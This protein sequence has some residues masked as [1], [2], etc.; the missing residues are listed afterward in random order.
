MAC[1]RELWL[2]GSCEGCSKQRLASQQDSE[3]QDGP[4]DGHRRIAS[5]QASHWTPGFQVEEPGLYQTSGLQDGARP[6]AH[7]GP[8]ASLCR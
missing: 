8:P 6:A 3:N 7:V 4:A 1:P 5:V 2:C